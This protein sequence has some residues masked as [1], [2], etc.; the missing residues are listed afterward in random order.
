M[1]NIY[2]GKCYSQPCVSLVYLE[3]WHIQNPSHIQNTAK[4][5]SSNISFETLC[6]PEIFRTLTILRTLVYSEIKAYSEP[7]RISKMEYFI[8]SHTDSA[9]SM[10]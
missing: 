7:C 8:K 4:Y 10:Q 5:L 3:L 6:N 1:P 2:D 9:D